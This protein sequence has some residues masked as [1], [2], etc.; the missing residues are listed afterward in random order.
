MQEAQAHP[1]IVHH[2][3]PHES[4]LFSWEDGILLLALLTLLWVMKPIRIKG[5]KLHG[6]ER[7]TFD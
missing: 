5:K 3:H 6:L 7:R 1:S 4:H 2:Q